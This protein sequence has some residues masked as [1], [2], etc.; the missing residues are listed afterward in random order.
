MPARIVLKQNLELGELST[1]GRGSKFWFFKK[2][3]S[4]EILSVCI[5]GI[6]SFE[7]MLE[8]YEFLNLLFV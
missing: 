8:L 3:S 7:F 4:Q 1:K 6:K 2:C 5:A